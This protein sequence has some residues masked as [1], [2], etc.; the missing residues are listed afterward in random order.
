MSIH[1]EVTIKCKPDRIYKALTDSGDFSA[2]TGAP[3]NID[4]SAGGVFTSFGGQVSGRHIELKDNEM[5]VQAW[6][7]GGW[8]K[9]YW[10]PLK[11]F[12]E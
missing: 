8:H 5:L 4:R 3:A 7:V 2:A 9:M 6:R 1:Q 12:C 11:A 10:E